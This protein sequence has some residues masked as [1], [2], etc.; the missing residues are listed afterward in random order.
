M[1]KSKNISK[2]AHSIKNPKIV[3]LLRNNRYVCIGCCSTTPIKS[4]TNP[5][6]VTCKN[7]KRWILNYL[8]NS[9]IKDV[10]RMR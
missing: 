10:K 3:H 9:M 7:C 6:R 1:R 2:Y 4:T 5:L 8:T